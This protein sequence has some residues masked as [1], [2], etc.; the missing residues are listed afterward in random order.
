MSVLS[1]VKRGGGAGVLLPPELWQP[2]AA[3]SAL[4]PEFWGVDFTTRNGTTTIIS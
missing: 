4:P 1:N 2:L 3:Q